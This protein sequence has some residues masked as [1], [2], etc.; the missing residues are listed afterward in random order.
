MD[1]VIG[2][3]KA[4]EAYTD[5]VGAEIAALWKHGVERVSDS[6]LRAVLI[7]FLAEVAPWTF[8]VNPA[9]STG[10]NHPEWQGGRAG[11]VRNTVECCVAVDRQLQIYPDLTDN[12]AEAK[13]EA[14]NIVLIATILSD[15]FKYGEAEIKEISSESKIDKNHGRIAAERWRAAA[16]R[17]EIRQESVD[18]IYEAIYWHL[19]RFTPGWP[20]GKGMSLYAAITHRIDMFFS[21]KS[22]ELLYDAKRV[23]P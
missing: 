7:Y 9:S 12:N 11:I 20:P 21:D 8:F 2:K 3:L 22:L 17:Y 19:G 5:L 6:E 1:A 16:R 13:P 23:V 4:M 14:R 10:R 15:T 18:E